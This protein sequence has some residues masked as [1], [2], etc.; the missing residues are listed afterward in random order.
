MENG[1]MCIC[2]LDR[3]LQLR[4]EVTVPSG[5]NEVLLKS[6]NITKDLIMANSSTENPLVTTVHWRQFLRAVRQIWPLF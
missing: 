3:N 6:L 2:E 5:K 4:S 1:K